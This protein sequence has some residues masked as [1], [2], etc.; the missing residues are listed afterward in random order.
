MATTWMTPLARR[1]LFSPLFDEFF[2]DFFTVPAW[3]PAVRTTEGSGA[4]ARARMDVLDKGEMFE[5]KVDLPGVKKE[6]IDVSVEGHRV[7][8][9]AKV[10]EE[11]EVKEGDRLLH[12]ERSYTSYARVFELPV[13][14]SDTGAEAA[15]E[16]GVLTLTLPKR[17]SAT[18]KRLTVH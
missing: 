12:A 1:E 6:D 15:Y 4:I 9:S 11:K 5:V 7:S 3:A 17:A 14:V 2:D 10:K 18:T 13:E 8:I 16:N